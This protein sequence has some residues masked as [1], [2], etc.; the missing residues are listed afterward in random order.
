[1][2]KMTG[3]RLVAH[4]AHLVGASCFKTCGGCAP[5]TSPLGQGRVETVGRRAGMVSCE[6]RGTKAQ[7]GGSGVDDEQLGLATDTPQRYPW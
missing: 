5:F 1:M 2:G 4:E 6:G 3:T 7:A